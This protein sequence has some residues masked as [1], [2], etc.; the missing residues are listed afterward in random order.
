MNFEVEHYYRS[1]DFKKDNRLFDNYIST[2]KSQI[3]TMGADESLCIPIDRNF[4]NL[5]EILGHYRFSVINDNN[6]KPDNTTNT[7]SLLVFQS[8]QDYKV[9]FR[10]H[11][12]FRV[13]A[14]AV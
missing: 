2:F 10:A 14:Y 1:S 12:T 5:K 3:Q 11:S 13:A 4:E 8:Q 9:R 7:H 6:N